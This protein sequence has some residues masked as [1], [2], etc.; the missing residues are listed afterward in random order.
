MRSRMP[1]STASFAVPVLLTVSLAACGGS[2]PPPP[3]PTPVPGAP[4]IGCPGPIVREGLTVTSQEVSFAGPDTIGGAPPV[5]AA[6]T[7]ASGSQFPL[8]DTPVTCTA[9][10]ALARQATCSFIVRLRHRGFALTRY[11][12]FGD[13]LTEGE[14]GRPIAGFIPFIDVANAYPTVLQQMFAE[15]IP[16]Q[17]IMVTNAGRGGERVTESED[18]L[19]SEISRTGAEVLLLLQGINDLNAGRSPGAVVEALSDHIAKAKE[20]G[21]RHVFVSTLLPVAPENCGTPPPRCRGLDT[22]NA[23]VSTTNQGIRAMVPANGAILVDPYD[24]FFANRSTYVDIDGL[25]MR[26]AGYRALATAFWD[27]LVQVIPADQLFGE[28]R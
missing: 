15:R 23:I 9:T 1:G 3:G 25:H 10:D 11:L 27:R 24:A 8:G 13:S 26:P 5:T 6:C 21:V 20:R 19:K 12:A 17:Q 2:A 28:V 7:P 18:R 4:Q 16:T 22:T 14:N